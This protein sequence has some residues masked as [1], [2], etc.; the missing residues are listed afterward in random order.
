MKSRILTLFPVLPQTLTSAA[1][2]TLYPK[3]GIIPTSHF[4]FISFVEIPRQK[5]LGSMK[6]DLSIVKDYECYV[7]FPELLVSLL[8][9]QLYLNQTCFILF[10]PRQVFPTGLCLLFTSCEAWGL[11]RKKSNLISDTL[12]WVWLYFFHIL[13]I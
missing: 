4:S 6:C 13:L 10:F 12:F 8:N 1:H 2:L 5:A 3:I 7:C 11:Q 9:S